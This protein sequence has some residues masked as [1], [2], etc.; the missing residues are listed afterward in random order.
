MFFISPPWDVAPEEFT[1][2]DIPE[3]PER[4]D[5]AIVQ[6]LNGNQIAVSGLSIFPPNTLG[7]LEDAV[8]QRRAEILAEPSR[9]TAPANEQEFLTDSGLLGHE[10]SFIEV[11][12]IFHREFFFVMPDG[13][14]SRLFYISFRDLSVPEVDQMTRTFS[15]GVPASL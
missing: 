3:D 6:E 12:F 8:S 9:F 7:A 15:A 14:I 1:R 10:F 13:A 5:F 4:E 2:N 11:D